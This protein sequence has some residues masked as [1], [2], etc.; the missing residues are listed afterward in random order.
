MRILSATDAISPAWQHTRDLLLVPRS[1]R[2]FLKIGLVAFF[3]RAGGCNGNYS[4]PGVPSNHGHF[5][6]HFPGSSPVVSGLDIAM[7][8]FA[9]L[10]LFLIGL[11]FFYLASRLQFVFFDVVLRRQTLIAPIWRRYAGITWPWIGLKIIFGLIVVAILT[12]LTLPLILYFIHH[13]ST[14]DQPNIHNVGPMIAVFVIFF[15]AIFVVGL[16]VGTAYR[17][18]YDFGLPSMALE[19]TSLGETSKR[20][21]RLFRAE[22]GQVLLYVLMHF[23]LTI[24]FG[25]VNAIIVVLSVIVASIPLGGI[26]VAL[27]FALRHGAMASHV[28]LGIGLTLLA[29]IFLALFFALLLALVAWTN[30]FFQAYAL[31]FLGGRYPLLGDL[32]EQ[33]APPP[34]AY[35]PPP[36]GYYPPYGVPPPLV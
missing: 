34:A 7:I 28:A 35:P 12:P 26:G 18:L 1:W 15:I 21:L 11:A 14:F 8:V 23:V 31:Y 5:P 2:L 3:A 36:P 29:L 16:V 32:L 13:A 24:A 22:P 25:I 33:H 10:L 4:S 20:V 27:Y 6:P 19:G 17:L 9:L 30:T